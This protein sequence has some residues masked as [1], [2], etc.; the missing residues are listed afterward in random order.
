MKYSFLS[1]AILLV[2]CTQGYSQN[3]Q[4]QQ[5][6]FIKSGLIYTF[7]GSD[8]SINGN[9]YLNENF[10][11][12][13]ISADSS[14]L[15]SVR[16][17]LVS[18]EMEMELESD[19]TGIIAINKTIPGISVTFVNSGKT[20]QI[21]DYLNNIGSTK[22]GYFIDLSNPNDKIKL[23]LKQSKVYFEGKPTRSGYQPS[24]P[25]SFKNVED[26]FFVKIMEDNAFEV[27]KNKKKIASL[28]P[29]HDSSI[30]SFI[31]KNKIKVSKEEDLVKLF[32]FINTL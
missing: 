4:H 31:K 19:K 12:A 6:S 24:T 7:D 28:F 25:P 17:N 13:R 16:Y 15:F 30:L 22:K 11:S 2:F 10:T 20:Y 18:D 21:F 8:K 1:L 9:P 29:K 32:N 23:L 14:K 27:K 5:P 26:K 3:L